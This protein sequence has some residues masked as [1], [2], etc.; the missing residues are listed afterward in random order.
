MKILLIQPPNEV[1]KQ[2][3][4]VKRK[5][6]LGHQPPLGLGYIA[7]YL[8]MD[9]HEV[10]IQDAAARS[11]SPEEAVREAKELE[12]D[13]IGITVLTNYAETVT[14]FT[15]VLKAALPDC[16]ILIG[17]AHA[18]Y[19]HETIL[20]EMPSADFVLYGEVDTVVRDFFHH[21]DS[22]EK[23]HELPGLVYRDEHGKAVVNPAPEMVKDLDTVP[24]PAWHLFDFSLYRPLP[25]QSV[26]QPFFTMVT[27]RGCWWRRCTFCF[28][29]GR[30]A[31]PFRRHSPER[32]I[33][34]I[35]HLYNNYGIREIAFWDDTFIVNLKWHQQFKKLLEERGLDITW[36][37]SGRLDSLSE[38]LLRT[39]QEAGCWNIFIGVESGN[40]EL[41]DVIDKGT[42]LEQARKVFATTNRLGIDTRGAFM[43]G[44]PGET[45]EMGEQTARF[46][47]EIEPT[48]AIFYATH[49]RFGTLLYD[50]AIKNGAFLDKSFHGMSKVTYVP[51][52]YESAEQLEEMVSRAYRKFYLRPKYIWRMLKKIRSW[53]V[54]KEL[55][56]GWLLFVGLSTSKQN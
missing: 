39:V 17:G 18:T 43:L 29:A 55:F 5:V 6:Q 20:D 40:Q 35:E 25:M 14:S 21:L 46:A 24:P 26:R 33:E 3:Y 44:L 12:P 36:T 54:V 22:P 51:E 48:Y 50:I 11:L 8:E 37:A 30:K 45:P 28:Q 47:R 34:E 38:D 27:S 10:V 41:L 4:G 49:P 2:V 32:V 23:L 19:F 7:A 31:V 42:T 13:L 56:R 52:Q 53:Q 9:G 1:H 15:E 16:P